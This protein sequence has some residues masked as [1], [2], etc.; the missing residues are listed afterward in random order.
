MHQFQV[1]FYQASLAVD[2]KKDLQKDH[3]QI[4]A[5]SVIYSFSNY[6]FLLEMLLEPFTS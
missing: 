6:L 1:F 2:T 4:T 5:C 3:R